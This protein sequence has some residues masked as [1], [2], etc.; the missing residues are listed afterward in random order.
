MHRVV[1]MLVFIGAACVETCPAPSSAPDLDTYPLDCVGDEDCALVSIPSCGPCA[2]AETPLRAADADRFVDEQTICC[3]TPITPGV[4]CGACS[5]GVP[6]C[7][8]DV[9][10]IGD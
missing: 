10:T 8:D 1:V 6:R 9:C 5:S 2:C 3:D 4:A 7:R